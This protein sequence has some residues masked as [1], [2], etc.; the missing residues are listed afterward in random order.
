MIQGTQAELAGG[1]VDL[2]GRSIDLTGFVIRH[3][4]LFISLTVIAVLA[5]VG[6]FLMAQALPVSTTVSYQF[7]LTFKGAGQAEYPNK[8]PFSPQDII[9]TDVLE[10][11]WKAQE[12]QERIELANLTRSVTIS[13]SSRD[14]SMLQSE[15]EQKLANT[16]LTAAERQVL[17]T[18]FKS[19]LD[20]LAR[21]GFTITCSTSQLTVAQAERL[22]TAIP[23]EWARLSEAV[24]VT[25]YKFP[26]PQS[27]ALRGSAE[28][29]AKNDTDV[30]ASI[31]HAEL[32]RTYV[33]SV[34]ETIEKLTTVQGSELI[35]TFGGETLL[36]LQQRVVA[37]QRNLIMPVYIDTMAAA[38]EKSK[39][40]FVSITGVRRQMLEAALE[41]SEQRSEVLHDALNRLGSDQR[42]SRTN[43]LPPGEGGVLANV[44]GTFIDRV[45]E[46]A[47]K[48]QDVEYRRKLIERVVESDLE[49][50][51][52]KARV[53]FEAWL[54][55]AIEE[56]RH[57]LSVVQPS[58]ASTTQRLVSL[59]TRSQNSRTVRV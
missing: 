55:K 31:L 58:A 57:A 25:A 17:E 27:M 53:E 26:L 47:V 1:A 43:S 20:A 59:R 48:S 22:V 30:V 35:K 40:E 54:I 2:D 29:L 8:T 42:E 36:D 21:T 18:E 13:R 51:D 16:K 39:A 44:D 24:G 3:R 9:G 32:L 56:R 46:Q 49:V 38:Q 52:Q 34:S 11:L 15:Y 7:T 6:A 10:P 12:L 33:E 50:V 4:S 28:A 37:L 19:K 23:A 14:L 41:K 45:I 5:S